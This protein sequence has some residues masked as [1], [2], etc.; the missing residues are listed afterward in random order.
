MFSAVSA[1]K[2]QKNFFNCRTLT[3]T[4][5]LGVNRKSLQGRKKNLLPVS[6]FISFLL[7]NNRVWQSTGWRLSGGGFSLGWYQTGIAIIPAGLDRLTGDSTWPFSTPWHISQPAQ[8]S[9]CWQRKQFGHI[10]ASARLIE[11]LHLPWKW[12]ITNGLKINRPKGGRKYFREK[13]CLHGRQER[14][15]GWIILEHSSAR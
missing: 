5:L 2:K 3:I 7:H 1:R 13:T 9:I 4:T 10:M 14:I 11:L 15:K 12:E 6:A 8:C